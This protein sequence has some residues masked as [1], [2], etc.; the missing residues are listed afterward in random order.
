MVEAQ[1]TELQ[2]MQ[3]ANAELLFP[4]AKGVSKDPGTRYTNAMRTTL[5]KQIKATGSDRP[6]TLLNLNPTTL[7]INGGMLFTEVIPAC[8][9]DE[10]Y[11]IYVFRETRWTHKDNGVGLDNVHKIDPFPVIPKVL[12]AEY[13]REYQQEKDGFGG[14][15]CYVGD[16]H[17]STIKKGQTVMVPVV[18]YVDGELVMDEEERDFHA[19]LGIVRSKRNQSLIRDVQQAVTWHENPETAKNVNDSHRDKARMAKREGLIPK[20]PRFC[21]EE[22]MLTEKQADAC[23]ICRVVPLA[24]AIMCANCNYVIDVVETFRLRPTECVYGSAEMDR[25]TPEQWKIVDAIH[26]KRTEIRDARKNRPT[27]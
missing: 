19:L 14:V 20:L 23:P 15:L 5:E 12:A 3:R 18:T 1:L 2:V 22:N 9:L 17:P 4:R 13:M 25:L 21:L 10:P 6:V 7:Q 26:A 16:H 27:Q 24:G 8:P 11:V